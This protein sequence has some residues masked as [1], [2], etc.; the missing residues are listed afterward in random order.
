MRTS[1]ALEEDPALP[2]NEF[3]KVGTPKGGNKASLV[4]QIRTSVYAN[5]FFSEL[6][7]TQV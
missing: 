2:R 1:V 6:D 4:Q 5:P 3:S 7:F